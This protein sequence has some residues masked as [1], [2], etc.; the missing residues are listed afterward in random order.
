MQF[1]SPQLYLYTP[2]EL[3]HV[4]C[5]DIHQPSLMFN[6]AQHGVTVIESKLMASHET[7]WLWLTH[8]VHSQ[9]NKFIRVRVPA[10]KTSGSLLPQ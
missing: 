6:P 1:T 3:L 2:P 4:N 5:P 7:S 9:W 10:S 8:E